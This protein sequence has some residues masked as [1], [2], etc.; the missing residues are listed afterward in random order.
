MGCIFCD[1]AT[2]KIP[3]DVV[4]ETDH[5]LAFRDIHPQAPVHILLIPKA[6]IADITELADHREDILQYVT[7]AIKAIVE[8][9]GIKKSGF[10]VVTNVGSD[11]GQTVFHLHFHILGG[12]A[13]TWPPG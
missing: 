9:F 10:R 11:G 4:Y 12:R 7:S 2:K 8:Q 5:V 6:H 13:M 3:A 1:I